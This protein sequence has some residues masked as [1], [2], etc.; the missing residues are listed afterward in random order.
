MQA[1]TLAAV[2][3]STASLG[4]RGM[5][6]LERME[7]P[8]PAGKA[9]KESRPQGK[10]ENK[11]EAKPAAKPAKPAAAAAR[12]AGPRPPT[13]ANPQRVA[14]LEELTKPGKGAAG[15]DKGK[16]AKR[17]SKPEAKAAPKAKKQAAEKR[18]GQE[19]PVQRV[20]RARVQ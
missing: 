9:R 13:R 17:S 14:S 3:F 5:R 8:K 20:T 12:P 7:R 1:E 11:Q 15:K 19:P 6:L 4:Q 2:A 18:K 10:A 16:E